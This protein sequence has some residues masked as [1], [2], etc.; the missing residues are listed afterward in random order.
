MPAIKA[1]DGTPDS[2]VIERLLKEWQ[3]DEII[4]GFA[5]KWTAPNSRPAAERVEFPNRI[6]GRFGVLSRR[7][8]HDERLS[9]VEARFRSV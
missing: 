8:F 9:T 2:N 3:P 6:H 7:T 5:A 4:V 1:Q